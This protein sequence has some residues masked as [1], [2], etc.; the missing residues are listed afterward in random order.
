M[1]GATYEMV[2]ATY[3]VIGATYIMGNSGYIKVHHCHLKSLIISNLKTQPNKAW[4]GNIWC[5]SELYH[6]H[7][8]EASQFLCNF[9]ESGMNTNPN[10]SITIA[11]LQWKRTML[12]LQFSVTQTRVT[13]W[14]RYHSDVNHSLSLIKYQDHKLCQYVHQSERSLAGQK[15]I[16]WSWP[17]TQ[18]LL[19]TSV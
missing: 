4:L 13:H 5:R 9:W 1:V 3:I 18:A 6:I 11:P 10:A 12:V 8:V 19:G 2:G 7:Y 14:S 17:S 15:C 16:F